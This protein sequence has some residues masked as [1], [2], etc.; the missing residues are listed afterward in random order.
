MRG[1]R[2]FSQGV[3]GPGLRPEKSLDVF[4]SPQLI[5]QFTEGVQLYQG[6]RGGPIFSRGWVG[7]NANFYRNPYNL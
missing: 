1:S 6:S 7:P 5:L 2:I 4:F 3:G